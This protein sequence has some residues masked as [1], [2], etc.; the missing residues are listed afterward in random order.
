MVSAV[1]TR[2]GDVGF[3]AEEPRPSSTPRR[4]VAQRALCAFALAAIGDVIQRH[5]DSDAVAACANHERAPTKRA[6]LLPT[7]QRWRLVRT[8]AAT[9][10][11]S[12]VIRKCS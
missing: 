11:W 8:E 9:S 7:L 12:A 6:A 3:V 1:F 10:V 4:L 2:G 5:L